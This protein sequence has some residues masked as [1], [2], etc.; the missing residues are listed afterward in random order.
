MGNKANEPAVVDNLPNGVKSVI[1]GKTTGPGSLR[2]LRSHQHR[3]RGSHLD[4]WWM[5]RP[6]RGR[7]FVGNSVGTENR[8]PED[9]EKLTEVP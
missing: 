4:W 1:Y 6:R 3:L 7:V 9:D 5:Y 8:T 2:S